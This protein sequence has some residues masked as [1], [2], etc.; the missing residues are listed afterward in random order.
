MGAA[1]GVIAFVVVVGFV[2]LVALRYRQEQRRTAGWGQ[3]AARLGLS[4]QQGDPLGLAERLGVDEVKE[5]VSGTIDGERVAALTVSK[6]R[7]FPGGGAR[8]EREWFTWSVGVALD[9]AGADGA[10]VVVDREPRGAHLAQAPLGAGA[11]E[12]LLRET[13]AAG[14][15][16]GTS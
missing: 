15:A 9:A 6:V 13:A 12:D 2:S 10:P 5:T 14:R 11:L 16:A 4:H 7:A 3:E 1:V 8:R